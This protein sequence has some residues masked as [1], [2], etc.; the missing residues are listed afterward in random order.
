MLL[1]VELVLSTNQ[2]GTI[3]E[4][5]L[6]KQLRMLLKWVLKIPKKYSLRK[7]EIISFRFWM[8]F[9]KEIRSAIGGDLLIPTDHG[10]E[11]RDTNSG[12]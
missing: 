8:T 10:S 4:Y 3:G 2:Q 7:P 11:V 9:R 1:T 5:F 6:K 12:D